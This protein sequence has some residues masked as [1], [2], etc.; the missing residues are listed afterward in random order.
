MAANRPMAVATSASEIPGATMAS[1][2]C[3]TLP[4]EEKALMIPHTVPN[5][6][7][8]GLVLPTVAR[9]ARLCSSRSI[10]FSCATRMAPPEPSSNWSAPVTLCRRRANSR[11]P[12]SKMPAM[13]VAPPCDSMARYS[14]ARSSPDQ[15]RLSKRSAS[16]RARPIARLLPKM[17]AHELSDASSRM[18]MTI[19]TGTLACTMSLRIDNCSPMRD[20]LCA[21]RL[22][23]KLRQAFG[24]QGARIHAGDP[25]VRLHE[26]VV[27]ACQRG[28]C[29]I[30]TLHEAQRGG[31]FGLRLA[32]DLQLIIE[33]RRR[34]VVHAQTHHGKHDAAVTRQ[35]PLRVPLRAQ[36]LGAGTLKEAQ[37]IGV[38]D[39]ATA[40]G[41]FPIDPRRPGKAAH[42]GSS[43]SCRVA[44]ARSGAFRPRCR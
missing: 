24:P 7:T 42:R 16:R 14:C 19:C 8:Y 32:G 35:L 6:P 10:S 41:V 43:N 18:P 4:S 12:N 29:A 31:A 5:S 27:A 30:D 38:I 21:Q 36:P 34:A 17:M 37:V 28:S 22:E 13:P 15:K 25:H 11:K 26:Q 23:Q 2:A 44:A 39:D 20:A 3:C 9:V 33:A 1:V 40:V